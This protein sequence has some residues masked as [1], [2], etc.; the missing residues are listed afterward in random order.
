MTYRS[1]L[2]RLLACLGSMVLAVSTARAGAEP[3][4]LPAALEI[5]RTSLPQGLR[6]YQKLTNKKDF[7]H[8]IKCEDLQLELATAVHEGIHVLTTEL[9]GYLLLDGRVLPR[10]GEGRQFFAPKVVAGQFKR[11][12]AFVQSYLMPGGATSAD[13]FAYLLDELNAYSHDLTVAARLT[14]YAPKDTHVYHRDGLAALMAFVGAYVERARVENGDTWAQLRGGTT[15]KTVAALWAQAEV[16][17]GGA[18]RIP[19]GG[20]EARDYLRPLCASTIKHGL[21]TL[22]GRPPLCPVS[23]LKQDVA[24]R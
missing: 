7:T 17:M 9:N 24:A 12:S 16:A 23:C 22:L 8:W 11:Q 6:V 2:V 3:P 19:S 21:G 4:C 15:P 18:C 1:G 14:R 5:L 20:L 13:E 10:V